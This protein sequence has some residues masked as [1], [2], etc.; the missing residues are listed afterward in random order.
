MDGSSEVSRRLA[1]VDQRRRRRGPRS[2][3]IL[4]D[5]VRVLGTITDGFIQGNYGQAPWGDPRELDSIVA[6]SAFIG[7]VLNAAP[8]LKS[9]KGTRA[10]LWTVSR[11]KH[12]ERVRSSHFRPVGQ[13]S[14]F[15]KP[16]VGGLYTSTALD[17]RGASMWHLY[18]ESLG[19]SLFPPPWITYL[20]TP[21]T[22]RCY[23][24][25]DAQAWWRLVMD[26][27]RRD[28]RVVYP[29]WRA[30]SEHY[31]G[32]HMSLP[33]VVALQGISLGNEEVVT[34]PGYWDAETTIWLNWAFTEESGTYVGTG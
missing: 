18:L 27:P 32:V 29:D 30:I 1:D 7:E 25:S 26:F 24:V 10:Q 8:G 4:T 3:C 17:V 5:L 2:G 33:A 19:G 21:R 12:P 15:G 14:R 28:G 16:R 6:S 11:P 13:A 31:D 34:A 23:E 9:H 20:L 22:T